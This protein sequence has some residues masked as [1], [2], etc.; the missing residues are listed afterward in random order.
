MKKIITIGREFGSGGRELGKQLAEKLGIAYYDNEIVEE[1]A[2]KTSLSEK[3]VKEILETKPISV[4]PAAVGRTFFVPVDYHTNV[5]LE[6]FNAQSHVIREMAAKSECV[7]VGRCADYILKDAEPFRIFVYADMDYKMARCRA[8][9]HEGEDLSDKRLKKDTMAVD[10]ARAQYY[11]FY[12]GQTWGNKLN[13]D[14]CVNTTNS[15]ISV[16]VDALA[17]MFVE[18]QKN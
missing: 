17:K 13:Y 4:M 12:T 14:I 18:S 9:A 16:V 10:K 1:I 3:Y 11:E 5:S 15:E 6:I 2:K 7:I 8:R